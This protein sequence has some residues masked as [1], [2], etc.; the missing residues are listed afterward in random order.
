MRMK[1]NSLHFKFFG[2]L[3]LSLLLSPCYMKGQTYKIPSGSYDNIAN[4]TQ[5]FPF[6]T[7]ND[8]MYS[9]SL[10]TISEIGN[11]GNISR[12]YWPNRNG[13]NPQTQT[14]LFKNDHSFCF[15]PCSNFYPIC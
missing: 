2:L 8:Y 12:V 11:S 3:V 13:F 14:I 5:P 6:G 15:R 4:P 7:T 10:Y 1:F 9:V